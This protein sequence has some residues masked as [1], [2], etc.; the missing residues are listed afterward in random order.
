MNI[1]PV[2][3]ST[4]RWRTASTILLL[5]L[6]LLCVLWE[7]WLAP[8]R[9]GGSWLTLKALPLL[10]ALPGLWRGRRYTYQWFSML[11]LLYVAEGTV[12][13]FDT[14]MAGT[15]AKA[16]TALATALFACVLGFARSTRP[17]RAPK[18]KRQGRE[19][20]E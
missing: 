10:L 9:P 8:L 1:P 20:L 6:A 18:A 7:G 15:L 3:S 14:G 19:G 4:A 11:V 13:F 17:P 5:L 16:E 12:R 2:S